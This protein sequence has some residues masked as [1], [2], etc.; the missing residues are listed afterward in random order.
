MRRLIIKCVFCLQVD[1]PATG[2]SFIN[3]SLQYIIQSQS[4]TLLIEKHHLMQVFL[5]F[6]WSRV[7]HVT[8]NNC[9][10]IMICSCTMLSSCVWL[11][12]I[13]CS[14]LNET[15]FFSFLWIALAWKWRSLCNNWLKKKL[16]DRMIN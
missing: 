6:H 3:D 7:Y 2:G 15:T 5:P 11:Q 12:I 9:L 1:G 10:I 14:C 13:F 4:F 8:C 16:S